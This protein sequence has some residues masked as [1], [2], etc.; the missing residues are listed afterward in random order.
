M[1]NI[2]YFHFSLCPLIKVFTFPVKSGYSSLQCLDSFLDSAPAVHFTEFL[3]VYPFKVSKVKYFPFILLL[4]YIAF[5]WFITTVKDFS[6]LSCMKIVSRP[7]LQH[8]RLKNYTSFCLLCLL[9]L[10]LDNGSSYLC[11]R[12]LILI[13]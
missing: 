1:N 13:C 6:F 3:I 2:I 4:I 7:N 5:S 9:S 12:V 11:C 8:R 10:H